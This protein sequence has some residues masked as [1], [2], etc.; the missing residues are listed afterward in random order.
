MRASWSFGR[1]AL[2][3][4]FCL[5]VAAPAAVSAQDMPPLA[6]AFELPDADG[7]PV[8]IGGMRKKPAILFFWATWCPFCKQM[9]PHLQS[10][11]DQYGVDVLALNIREDG[12]PQAVLDEYG[13][14][15]RLIPGADSVAPRYNV[16]GTPA[17]FVVDTDG[18][19]VFD[20]SLVQVSKS[21][22]DDLKRWQRAARLAPYWAAEM[23]K[24]LAELSSH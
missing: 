15:F 14:T 13:Y 20:L 22:P 23:R 3:G 24:A 16:R 2:F 7:N 6:P 12:D 17:I 1:V 10:A 4:L 5:F 8:A 18:Y 9:M 21:I 11:V 19:V